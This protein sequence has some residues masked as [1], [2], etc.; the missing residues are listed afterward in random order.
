MNTM[1]YEAMVLLVFTRAAFTGVRCWMDDG[2]RSV[3]EQR[4]KEADAKESRE[5][6]ETFTTQSVC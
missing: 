5:A 6:A 1:T 3:I 4:M 2:A